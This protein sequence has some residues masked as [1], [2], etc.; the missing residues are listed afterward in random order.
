MNYC[1]YLRKSRAD[2]DAEARGEGETL[3]RHERA[4]LD[5]AKRQKLNIVKIYREIVSGET[6]AARPVM[7]Q[8][9]NEVEQG[10]WTGVLVME[11]E[12]LARGDTVDQGIM[13][14]TFKYSNTKI[15]TPM[16]T[17]DPNNEFDEEY[18]EF[19]LF[20]SRRE[21][22]TINRRLQRGR[23]AS[24]QEGKYLGNTPPYG[25]VRKKLHNDKGY[26]LELHPEQSDIVKLIYE[27][28]TKGEMQ[29]EGIYNRLGSSL[30]ANKLNDMK[31]PPQ[32]GD[33]WVNS[34]V[35]GILTNPV[36]NGKIRW[37]ARPSVKKIVDGQ[38]KKERPRAKAQ[39]CI[40]VHGI[41][42]AIIDDD[43]WNLAQHY[44]SQN[45]IQPVIKNKAIKNP[46][47]GLVVCGKCNRK[48]IRR[49]LPNQ[50]D[51]LMC[52]LSS[53][54]NVSS[55]LEFVEKRIIEALEHWL[56]EYKMKWAIPEVEQ[57]NINIQL[58]VK[59]KAVKKIESELETLQKQLNNLHDLL[60][61][62]IYS[63]DKFLERSKLLSNK[64]KQ[65]ES[66]RDILLED[67]SRESNREKNRKFIIPKVEKV[68][69]V[70]HKVDDPGKKNALLKEVVEKVLYTKVVKGR[71]HNR[72]DDFELVLYP[73]LP[74]H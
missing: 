6:I 33:R 53:C 71:W 40:I 12:R 14:Q 45:T 42:E 63:T 61:Q 36:Y 70:Y 68:L 56:Q 47:A 10:I 18:F 48:L 19:G 37:N 46:L 35:R 24:V 7:Q 55:H 67:L 9:L 16:K 26:T 44:M 54:D 58:D 52:R 11:V 39:D 21:Y 72:P 23:L 38:I 27:L 28:Y 30:I 15:I 49:P 74:K 8:L 25:Y 73:K 50:P 13:T 64:V 41:H 60:E 62:G 66:D 2:L 3:I 4:L 31:I 22:K 5:L 29:S 65:L 59:E 51:I 34:S 32:K 20:M 17:Y 43:T 1:I 57:P 69:E